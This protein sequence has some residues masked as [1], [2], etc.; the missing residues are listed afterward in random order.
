MGNQTGIGSEKIYT[1]NHALS[2]YTDNVLKSINTMMI[3]KVLKFDASKQTVDVKPCI[4][5]IE[6]NDTSN[7]SMITRTGEEVYITHH[8]L[9]SILNVPIC[10][11]RSGQYMI[12]LPI[13]VGDTGMLIVSQ[14][15]LTNWKN[16]GG[17]QQQA[18]LS[19]FDMNDGIF[20]PFVPNQANIISDYNSSALEIRA[21]NDK[22]SMD[23]SG[24]LN[25]TGNVHIV[26]DVTVTKTLTATTDVVGGGKSLKS[27]TH[28]TMLNA[29]ALTPPT[30]SSA[31]SGAPN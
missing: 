15:D 23:G 9:P 1:L 13:E 18:E 22:I 28:T 25:I 4:M 31:T 7:V 30:T 11:P 14:R 24:T 10:H 6:K 8:E 5:G 17:I 16:K 26:G 12:T 2:A 20:L 29:S 3:V 19:I 27:H 21:K